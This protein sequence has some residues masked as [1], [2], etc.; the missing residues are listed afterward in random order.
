M[1]GY[2]PEHFIA[3]LLHQVDIVDLINQQIPLKKTGSEFQACCPFHTEKT[4]SFT[5]SPQKQFYHCFGCGAHGTAIRF[6]MEYEG[7]GFVDAIETLAQGL[8]IEVPKEQKHYQN[9]PDYRPLY[10]LLETIKTHYLKQLRQQT[11]A[12][13][14][15]K[16]RGLSGEI[17][18]RYQIGYAP[19]QWDFLANQYEQ[20]TLLDIGMLSES[21]DKKYDRFRGR[22]MFPIHDLRGRPI[23]FGGRVLDESKPKY[24]N[25]PETVL[26]HKGKQ[27]YGLF[28]A[29][30]YTRHLTRL[31]VVEGYMDVIALAQF[32]IHYAVATLGTATTL[33]HIKLCFKNAAEIIFCFDGDRAGKEAGWKA[34]KV[35]LSEIHEGRSIRFLFLPDG[36]DPDTLIRKEGKM[37]LEQRIN[38][39]PTLSQYLLDYLKQ[40]LDL[41]TV[42]GRGQL[43][44]KIKPY[45]AQIR[46][47][48]YVDMLIKKL[49]QLI[50]VKDYKPQFPPPELVQPAQRKKQ[51]KGQSL[52]TLSPVRLAIGLLLNYPEQVLAQYDSAPMDWQKL[53]IKGISLIQEMIQLIQQYKEINMGMI[54]EHWH[55]DSIGTHLNQLACI[56]LGIDATDAAEE[57]KGVL[58]QL[59]CQYIDQEIDKLQQKR[60]YQE[61]TKEEQ[62]HLRTL[63]KN[64]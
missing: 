55:H 39:A 9:K 59:S 60:I 7:L 61:L 57:F 62:E 64:R 44:A 6:L 34:L 13:D 24:L 3:D 31:M 48:L 21:K 5:V 42:E 35:S 27:L 19:N 14:Y 23:G 58:R 18:A 28:Q 40:D 1:A 50:Q 32:D 56:P 16:Q 51:Y 22:I 30:K 63:L 11:N 52:M 46:P 10:Q 8:G 15:L 26:F 4:P 54:L 41:N 17:C 25:S 38:Q 45:L 43:E 37:G 2:I 12:I 49:G 29:R 36:E 53:E 47:G 20:K 33:D